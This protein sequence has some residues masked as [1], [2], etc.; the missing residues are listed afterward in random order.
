MA[1]SWDPKISL[2]QVITFATVLGAAIAGGFSFYYKANNTADKVDGLTTEIISMKG[3]V[4]DL[5]KTVSDN[6]G[7]MGLRIDSA[8]QGVKQEIGLLR[9]DVVKIAT[10]QDGQ[11]R[12]IDDIKDDLP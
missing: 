1:I 8:T 3:D 4:K 9:I 7:N 2:G 6:N 11:Q 5:N 10:Q 12:Q